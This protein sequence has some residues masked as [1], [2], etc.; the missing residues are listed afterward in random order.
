M[1]LYLGLFGWFLMSIAELHQI[2]KIIKNKSS[3]NISLIKY[4]LN[5]AGLSIYLI[6]AITEHSL[7]FTI[8]NTLALV[9]IGLV[10]IVAKK[11]GISKI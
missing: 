4:Y 5:L 10:I 7:F 6:K 8:V 11:Y 2:F 1:I 3:T 9:M